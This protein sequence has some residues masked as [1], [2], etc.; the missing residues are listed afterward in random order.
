[1]TLLT[2]F[3]VS[4][5]VTLSAYFLSKKRGPYIEIYHRRF[6]RYSGGGAGATENYTYQCNHP[7]VAA[8]VECG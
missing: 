5:S 7:G 3:L 8:A 6:Y 1:M 4:A 2:T